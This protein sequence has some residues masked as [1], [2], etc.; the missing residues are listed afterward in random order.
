MADT[1]ATL[2]APVLSAEQQAQLYLQQQL[3]A[4]AHKHV[5]VSYTLIGVLVVVLGLAGLGGWLALKFADKQI[6]RAEATEQRFEQAQKDFQTQLATNTAQRAADT[7]QQGVIVKVVDTRD[8]STDAKIQYVLQPKTPQQALTDLNEA[9]TGTVD[10]SNTPVTPDGLLSFRV[11]AVQQF[12]ATKIDRDRLSADLSSYK[13]L[14]N[15]EQNKTTTLT[16]D[17][18]KSETTLAACQLTVT[19]YKKAATLSKFRK[20]LNG[21][22]KAGLLMLGAVAGYEIGHKL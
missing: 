22:E 13:G 6:A 20:F 17:L 12:S 5:S 18:T 9:Y 14:L 11:N 10:F 1:I 19:A 8:K 4:L 21:A 3:S 16:A 7:Q 2:A 15:L